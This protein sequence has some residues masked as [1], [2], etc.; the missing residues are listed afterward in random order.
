MASTADIQVNAN[1]GRTTQEL[2]R[3]ALPE[4]WGRRGGFRE[5][6]EVGGVAGETKQ[7]VQVTGLFSLSL[8]PPRLH[9]CQKQPGA[10]R[11]LTLSDANRVVRDGVQSR[12]QSRCSQLLT[13]AWWMRINVMAVVAAVVVVGGKSRLLTASDACTRKVLYLRR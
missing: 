4:R 1:R 8:S 9:S 13:I 2:H 7:E 6:E 12:R 3:E 10:P 5:E 11:S